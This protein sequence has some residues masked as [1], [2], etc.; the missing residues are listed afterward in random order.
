MREKSV[1]GDKPAALTDNA[2]YATE[3]SV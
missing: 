1:S 2:L 3:P